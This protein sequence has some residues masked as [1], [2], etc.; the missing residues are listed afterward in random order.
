MQKNKILKTPWGNADGREVFLFK[1]ENQKGG[2]IELSNYGATLVS[3]F[4]QDNKGRKEN[5]ILGFPALQGYVNDQSYMGSTVGRFANRISKATFNLDGKRVTLEQ[6][7]DPNSNHSGSAGFNKK[8]FDYEIKE[9]ILVF[10]LLSPDGEGGFPGNLKTEVHYHWNGENELTIDYYGQ[11][12][13]HTLFNLTNHSYFDLSS[14]KGRMVDHYL[15]VFSDQIVE[16]GGDYIPTGELVAA[17]EAYTFNDTRI[18]DRLLQPDGSLKGLNICYVL[19]SERQKSSLPAARLFDPHSGRSLT[20]Y[21]SYP[22]LMLYTGDYLHTTDAGFNGK[23]YRPF[24][25]MCLEAQFFPDSPNHPSFPSAALRAGELAHHYI[26]FKF[27]T[28]K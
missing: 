13:Q 9:D 26:I 7:D 27:D 8:V 10:S 23:P 28:H 4:V 19:D 21:T 14:G 12:D 22:G 5:V 25:G 24:D 18:E 16:A 6:N 17:G 11:T 1:I 2:F 20:L 3:V 15:S